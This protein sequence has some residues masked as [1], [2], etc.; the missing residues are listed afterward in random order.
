[1][2]LSVRLGCAPFGPL[3]ASG[4][5]LSLACHDLANL[6]DTAL[7]REEGGLASKATLQSAQHRAYDLPAFVLARPRASVRQ[8]PLEDCL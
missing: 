3:Q 6:R 2:I 4:A 1:M 8:A 7:P 5:L